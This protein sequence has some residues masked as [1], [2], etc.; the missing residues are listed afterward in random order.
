MARIV[1]GVIIIGWQ[2]HFM[3]VPGQ[4]QSLAPAECVRGEVLH[5]FL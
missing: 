5:Q 2:R 3:L 1:T 4:E